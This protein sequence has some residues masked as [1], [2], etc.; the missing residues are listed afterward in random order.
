MFD[1]ISYQVQS[2]PGQIIYMNQHIHISIIYETHL[3]KIVRR[4]NRVYIFDVLHMIQNPH[5]HV[6]PSHLATKYLQVI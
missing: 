4:N 3:T 6:G 5:L 1:Q 2:F